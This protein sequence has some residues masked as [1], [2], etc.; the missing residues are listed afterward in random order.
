MTRSLGGSSK[1]LVHKRTYPGHYRESPQPVT[2]RNPCRAKLPHSDT[3]RP[4][5]AK[6]NIVEQE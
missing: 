3:F 5:K 6:T 2:Q 1:I 4:K